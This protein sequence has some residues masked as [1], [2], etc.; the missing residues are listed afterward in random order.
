MFAH[1][2][3]F[4]RMFRE[5]LLKNLES[6]LN[7]LKSN[8]WVNPAGYNELLAVLADEKSPKVNTQQV[9]AKFDFAASAPDELDL[10]VGDLITVITEIDQD[11]YQ[12][13]IGN[14]TGIFP[15]SFVE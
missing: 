4:A 13:K 2:F 3:D 14:K 12:G 9:R 11:W 8:N 6:D 7:A 1:E 5:Y 15:R 10:H